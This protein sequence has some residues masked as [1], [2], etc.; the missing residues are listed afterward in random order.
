MKTKTDVLAV[1]QKLP[2]ECWA[3]DVS[4][5]GISLIRRGVMGHYPREPLPPE[6][7]HLKAKGDYP[8]LHDAGRAYVAELNRTQGITHEQELAMEIGSMFGWEVPGADPDNH[9]KEARSDG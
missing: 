4:R 5:P 9:R 6:L 3:W 1:L 2:P 7:A 8:K